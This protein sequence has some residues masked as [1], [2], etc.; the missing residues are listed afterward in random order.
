MFNR[1]YYTTTILEALATL[2]E[3][4]AEDLKVETNL[5]DGTPARVWLSRCDRDDGEPWDN[6]V[7]LET[8]PNGSWMTVMRWDGD[9]PR[10]CQ[11]TAGEPCNG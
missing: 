11:D 3:G 4:Q 7:S 5:D 1:Y 10:D 6:T 8:C 9:N 2:C